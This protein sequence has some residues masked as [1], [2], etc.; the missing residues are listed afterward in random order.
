MMRLISMH[1]YPELNNLENIL[2][3]VDASGSILSE[4]VAVLL[5][6]S[7]TTAS[8]VL[9]SAYGRGYLKR[10]NTNKKQKIGGPKFQYDLTF[11]GR[12]RID[13][14]RETKLA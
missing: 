2:M 5:G 12:K 11:D 7:L 8:N 4:D 9:R 13:W 6:V 14:I 1:K 3:E 10:K